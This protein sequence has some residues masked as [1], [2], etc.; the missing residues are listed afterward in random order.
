MEASILATELTHEPN[1]VDSDISPLLELG[2]EKEIVES[3]RR[4]PAL[5]PPNG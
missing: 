5:R 1:R 3:H 2:E 4:D